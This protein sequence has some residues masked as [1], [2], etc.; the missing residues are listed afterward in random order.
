M[1]KKIDTRITEQIAY[2]AANAAY[3]RSWNSD[4]GAR[5][6]MRMDAER[7]LN[8]SPQADVET[9]LPVIAAYQASR[10]TLDRAEAKTAT[11]LAEREALFK[12]LVAARGY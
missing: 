12:A 6:A 1:S 10:E 9:V 7:L 2:D 11:L 3:Q 5:M 4:L 8:I